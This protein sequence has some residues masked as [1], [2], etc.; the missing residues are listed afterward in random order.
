MP[1]SWKNRSGADGQL[2]AT[3]RVF[4]GA[5]SNKLATHLDGVGQ[6]QA[7][8]RRTDRRVIAEHHEQRH[9]QCHDG[10]DEIQ[11]EG[12]PT[13][14]RVEQHEVVG[15]DVVQGLEPA[16]RQRREY[17]DGTEQEVFVIQGLIPGSA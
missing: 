13:R 6:C 7:L 1:V 12:E 14:P 15:V 9:K 17:D 2:A 11:Q 10:C 16:T 4:A 5:H 3:G 8:Q